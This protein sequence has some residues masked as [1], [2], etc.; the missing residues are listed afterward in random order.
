MKAAGELGGTAVEQ[1]RD[2]VTGTISGVKVIIR[3]P[4]K[5]EEEEKK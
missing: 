3:E 2:A 1:V 5:G 4:F